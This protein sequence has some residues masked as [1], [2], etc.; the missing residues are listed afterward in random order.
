MSIDLLFQRQE[1]EK[2]NDQEP[3]IRGFVFACTNK[4]ESECLSR[5]LFATDKMY[6]PIVI[7]IRK[8]DLLFLNNIDTDKLLG[9]FR[10]VSDGGVNIHSDAFEGRYSYQVKVEK[11][12][13]VLYLP[14]AKNVLAKLAIKRN[15]PLFKKALVTL[16]NKYLELDI[17]QTNLNGVLVHDTGIKPINEIIEKINKNNAKIDVEGIFEENRIAGGAL[18]RG[19]SQP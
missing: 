13:D 7:R 18:P 19:L 4:S 15:T 11:V 9:I 1:A 5:L 16:L 14:Y 10:A 3:L 6:G 12:G 2:L 17:I 8:G